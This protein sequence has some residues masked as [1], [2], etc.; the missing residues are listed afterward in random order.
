MVI[1]GHFST[2]LIEKHCQIASFLLSRTPRTLILGYPGLL[3]WSRL[4]KLTERGLVL[5]LVLDHFLTLFDTSRAESE[6][7][8]P[9]EPTVS[10]I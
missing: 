1:S 2:V 5:D 4:A 8:G 9:P 7:E 10:M 3:R 6:K